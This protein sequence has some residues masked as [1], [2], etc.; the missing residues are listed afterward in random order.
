[1]HLSG[2]FPALATPVTAAGAVDFGTLDRLSDFLLERGVDGLCVGGA[3]AEYP[4]FEQAERLEI[5]RRVARR[6]P[7]GVTLLAAIGA[8]SVPRVL[9]LGRAA[10]DEGYRAVLLPMPS[11]F[12][13]QQLDLAAYCAFVSGTL[14]GPC[15]LYD[16]PVFTNPIEPETTLALLSSEPHVTGIKDSSG[17]V[18]NLLRFAEARGNRDWTLLVGDD[19]Y[20][21]ASAEAG[22]DG[23]ISGIACCCPELLVALH[24]SARR[25]DLERAR[26]CQG[27]VDE[28]ITHL[29]VLPTPW[30]V[31]VALRA[32][33]LDTGPLPLPLP[34][35]RAVQIARIEAWLAGW[36]ATAD[37]PNLLPTGGHR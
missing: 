24:D 29:S 32:R 16:L 34:S 35:E 14:G 37:V 33:G 31:R 25:G 13:Y 28:L 20:G 6:T 5:L 12:R 18:E 2:L 10:F 19:R 30:G 36:L 9:E 22:W 4:C 7:R 11:F 3:T 8:S 23:A 26:R 21:L 27:L 17:H 1:M 15:L